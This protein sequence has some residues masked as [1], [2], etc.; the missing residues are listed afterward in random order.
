M[1]RASSERSSRPVALGSIVDPTLDPGIA[2]GRELVAFA[3]AAVLRDDDEMTIARD[4]LLTVAGPRAVVRA[5]GVVGTFEMMN[6]LL[7]GIG[8]PIG[9]HAAPMAAVL[10]VDV[11]DHI[12]P[13]V[14]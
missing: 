5:A 1:L 9:A 11:P 14:R 12:R 7:D 13:G 3:D 10:G 2:A 6:R 8:V 4:R